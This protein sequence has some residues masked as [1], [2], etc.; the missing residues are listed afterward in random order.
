[1][2]LM[3]EECWSGILWLSHDVFL[4]IWMWHRLGKRPYVIKATYWV[5]D[6][7]ML[8]LTLINERLPIWLFLYYSTDILVAFLF[9][10]ITSKLQNNR[11]LFYLRLAPTWDKQ[12]R[13]EEGI[14]IEVFKPLAKSI[15]SQI[16]DWANVTPGTTSD[17]KASS[18]NTRLDPKISFLSYLPS[19]VA[20]Y[21][22]SAGSLS[23]PQHLN[24]KAV[25]GPNS[26]TTS[27]VFYLFSQQ[28]LISHV[29]LRLQT[30]CIRWWFPSSYL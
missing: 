30:P 22:V 21:S 8:M 13:K 27:F 1:M 10:L 29:F 2:T 26:Q 16:P 14:R 12:H 9:A 15:S 19:L 24:G 7:C 11:N 25:T 6:S 23:V 5:H 17:S 3:T 4:M 18:F 20:A 28:N